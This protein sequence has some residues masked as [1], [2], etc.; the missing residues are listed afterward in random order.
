M[1]W[2]PVGYVVSIDHCTYIFN[3]IPIRIAGNGCTLNLVFLL[4]YVK[5]PAAEGSFNS[6]LDKVFFGRL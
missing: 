3:R 1:N 5:Y 2:T 4:D 6:V